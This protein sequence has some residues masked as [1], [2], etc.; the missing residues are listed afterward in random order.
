MRGQTF[1]FILSVAVVLMYLY[2][3]YT[4]WDFQG[5]LGAVLG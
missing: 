4:L 1:I 2:L 3:V 5:L